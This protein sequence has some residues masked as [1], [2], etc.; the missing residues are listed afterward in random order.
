MLDILVMPVLTYAIEV[1]GPT[2]FD[3]R[4]LFDENSFK[5]A[6]E[7]PYIEKLNVK[8]CKYVL[9]VS[10]KSCNDAV[11]GELGRYPLVLV[12]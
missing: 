1:W 12:W 11:R 10:R 6:L 2:S 4:K 3:S 7:A 9:G 8:L 5:H